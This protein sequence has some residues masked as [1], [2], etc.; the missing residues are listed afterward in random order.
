MAHMA[1]NLTIRLHLRIYKHGSLSHNIDEF[2]HRKDALSL[3][4]H[5]LACFLDESI[6][7]IY[8]SSHFFNAALSVTIIRQGFQIKLVLIDN[9]LKVPLLIK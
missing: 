2:E 4:L 9:I 5:L 6:R 1:A 7:I 8:V 3:Y